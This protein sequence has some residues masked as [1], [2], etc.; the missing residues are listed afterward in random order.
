MPEGT[1]YDLSAWLRE[2]RAAGKQTFDMD[3]ESFFGVLEDKIAAYRG[4]SDK[5]GI[6][7]GAYNPKDNLPGCDPEQ[8]ILYATCDSRFASTTAYAQVRAEMSDPMATLQQHKEL[9]EGKYP[10][11]TV[12]IYKRSQTTAMQPQRQSAPAPARKRSSSPGRRGY[13]WG[14]AQLNTQDQ[15]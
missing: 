2:R 14:M 13:D 5:M 1:A 3:N 9:L 7:L 4:T 12:E 8:S 15:E 11:I 6:R 10:E